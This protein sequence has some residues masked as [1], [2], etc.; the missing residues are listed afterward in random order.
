M[1]WGASVHATCLIS[2]GA[3]QGGSHSVKQHTVK[4]AACHNAPAECCF[5]CRWG[6]STNVGFLTGSKPPEALAGKELQRAELI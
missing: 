1:Q 3:N 6:T 4:L 2:T 5:L